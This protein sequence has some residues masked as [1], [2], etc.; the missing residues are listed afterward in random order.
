MKNK[1]IILQRPF[2]PHF[3][4]LFILFL[5]AFGNPS[6]VFGQQRNAVT[7]VKAP[8]KNGIKSEKAV[9]IDGKGVLETP[10]A[11]Y[12]NL[13]PDSLCGNWGEPTGDQPSILTFFD[14]GNISSFDEF[15]FIFGNGIVATQD[16]DAADQFGLKLGVGLGKR[17]IKKVGEY[18]PLPIPKDPTFIAPTR[19]GYIGYNGKIYRTE[20]EYNQDPSG[21]VWITLEEFGKYPPNQGGDY[22]LVLK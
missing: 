15:Q 16:Q 8:V 19:H 10:K 21:N 11:E 12:P 22:K 20:K 17:G 14:D 7:T 18:Y 2:G 3:A 4:Q 13:F 1:S 6:F 9:S 5:F